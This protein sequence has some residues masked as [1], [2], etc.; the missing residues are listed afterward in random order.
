MR[1]QIGEW[2]LMS[3]ED[4]LAK[5]K[6][7]LDAFDTVEDTGH[8]SRSGAASRQAPM[9][10]PRGETA[11]EA[12]TVGLARTTEGVMA[13]EAGAESQRDAPVNLGHKLVHEAPTK[14]GYASED[15]SAP[16]PPPP[17]ET[18][19]VPLPPSVPLPKKDD[20]Q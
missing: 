17:Q 12:P 13:H 15:T 18:T 1:S 7:L 2:D 19:S 4:D 16:S 9:A 10:V 20:D 14:L 6:A 3:A 11:R 8:T 5:A